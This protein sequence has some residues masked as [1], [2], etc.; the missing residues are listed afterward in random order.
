MQKASPSS[1][2]LLPLPSPRHLEMSSPQHPQHCQGGHRHQLQPGTPMGCTSRWLCTLFT[3]LPTS[4]PH[5]CGHRRRAGVARH[6]PGDHGLCATVMPT[7]PCARVQA[8]A[9][10]CLRPLL[11][12]SKVLVL[13]HH[14]CRTRVCR[15]APSCAPAPPTAPF[16]PQQQQI[17][18]LKKWGPAPQVL[19]AA[20]SCAGTGFA[21]CLNGAL[22]A[23]GAVRC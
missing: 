9:P 1:G 11:L 4:Q 3:P 15:V 14:V 2:S 23:P 6:T 20:R 16:A 12:P 5:W 19:G 22:P 21:A 7:L 13:W 8:P 17:H 10:Q 18:L